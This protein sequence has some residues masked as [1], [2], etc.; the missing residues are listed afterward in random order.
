M[1]T[2]HNS[3][4]ASGSS[5]HNRSAT[6]RHGSSSVR[7]ASLP[8]NVP[9]EASAPATS[10]T[11]CSCR[12]SLALTCAI[13]C[14]LFVLVVSVESFTTQL[15]FFSN[16]LAKQ[17]QRRQNFFGPSVESQ[18][19]ELAVVPANILSNVESH[20]T[21]AGASHTPLVEPDGD[22][23]AVGS[24]FLARLMATHYYF[25]P[26]LCA[27][28]ISVATG[29]V[30]TY[31]PG[32]FFVKIARPTVNEST[33][34]SVWK[35]QTYYFTSS[36]SLS[37]PLGTPVYIPDMR[38]NDTE[39]A[40][41]ISP[42]LTIQ[43][44]VI[45]QKTKYGET[46]TT[47]SWSGKRGT[48][49]VPILRKIAVDGAPEL[50][51]RIEYATSYLSSAWLAP[52]G[53][54]PRQLLF[55][56]ECNI[57]TSNVPDWTGHCSTIAAQDIGA[58]LRQFLVRYEE[59]EL[60]TV[61]S[62]TD[63]FYYTIRRL[64]IGVTV[65]NGHW[66]ILELSV[67]P[68]SPW[69][70]SKQRN[71]QFTGILFACMSFACLVYFVFSRAIFASLIELASTLEKTA[72]KH[73]ASS[74]G[75]SDP[76]ENSDNPASP[77]CC[78]A[79]SAL[80]PDFWGV[81]AARARIV[82]HVDEVLSFV[83]RKVFLQLHNNS[84]TPP[85]NVSQE[86]A[87]EQPLP[88]D[89][90]TDSNAVHATSD[91]PIELLQRTRNVANDD[92]IG[93]LLRCRM[94]ALH[95]QILRPEA[96][97]WDEIQS[98]MQIAVRVVLAHRGV[99]EGVEYGI[100]AATF[101]CHAPSSEH[102]KDAVS[103]A[104]EIERRV[105]S[106]FPSIPFVCVTDSDLAA[107]VALGNEKLRVQAVLGPSLEVSRKLSRLD[108]TDS[109]SHVI[110]TGAVVTNIPMKT[111][112]V[113]CVR[114]TFGLMSLSDPLRILTHSNGGK[115]VHH[116]L[117]QPRTENMS[118][119]S[120]SMSC[121]F[122][123]MLEGEYKPAIETLLI[124]QGNPE[125]SKHASRLISMC[126]NALTIS[127]VSSSFRQKFRYVRSEVVP[128]EIWP[129]E[130]ESNTAL[131]SSVQNSM[132]ALVLGDD[133]LTSDLRL[134]TPEE[135]NSVPVSDRSYVSD[136]PLICSMSQLGDSIGEGSGS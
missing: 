32:D 93:Q 88:L 115:L 12:I 37:P 96:C 22:Q 31:V 95:F 36:L 134:S 73:H 24:V 117:P 17:M 5:I 39:V 63:N 47:G 131:W 13:V 55:D 72:K 79:L 3:A 49:F 127:C 107:S 46:K 133:G 35:Q 91:Q 57:I 2:G 48:R 74:G 67:V 51:L 119:A 90:H 44:V 70:N 62:N 89:G 42:L 84:T 11:C 109:T 124:L 26:V 111:I 20:I 75:N 102:E 136:P 108:L 77:P 118:P 104:L 126:Q 112:V 21:I 130:R 132:M 71:G 125:L 38:V 69:A 53:I 15:I 97:L 128:W 7:I 129:S 114:P 28:V 80:L 56:S 68:V 106:R 122:Q 19:L 65:L 78:S 43:R 76:A 23:F 16:E 41:M 64:D 1:F 82:T 50:L 52:V 40:Q 81:R 4:S 9:P 34:I 45:D 33:G 98:M 83:P 99:I 101:N 60:D 27:S 25:Q 14:S 10:R 100:V 58:I 113:D 8:G 94:S 123:D 135:N 85:L 103:S 18:F 29:L 120:F 105:S 110:A 54:E 87:R 6:T 59:E 92:E 121:A 66:F 116:V 30:L 86:E 61:S